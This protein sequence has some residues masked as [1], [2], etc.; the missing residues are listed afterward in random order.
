MWWRI[1]HLTQFCL[2]VLS[3]R[4][5][6][7]AGHEKEIL[8]LES[9]SLF[10]QFPVCNNSIFWTWS[11]SSVKIS[12]VRIFFDSFAI[13]KG[14]YACDFVN[15]CSFCSSAIIRHFNFVLL[16]TSRQVT[17]FWFR[18]L[19]DFSD[20]LHSDHFVWSRRIRIRDTLLKLTSLE[21]KLLV[22]ALVL[23]DDQLVNIPFAFFDYIVFFFCLFDLVFLVVFAET[24]REAAQTISL[25]LLN[26]V[27]CYICFLCGGLAIYLNEQTVLVL[28]DFS[29]LLA[30]VLVFLND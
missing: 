27:W 5:F 6:T 10:L 29:Y 19:K 9:I 15:F 23:L 1:Q 21:G 22:V 30:C 16:V 14:R 24:W 20:E 3:D 2:M 26:T 17:I 11:Q 25:A 4:S 28:F 7:R 12:Q 18:F 8:T 13:V